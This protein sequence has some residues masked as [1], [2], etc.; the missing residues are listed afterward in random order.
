MIYLG[1]INGMNILF[2]LGIQI[3][4]VVVLMFVSKKMWKALIKSLT[5]LGG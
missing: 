1:K 3:F 2:S 4:W 5:I